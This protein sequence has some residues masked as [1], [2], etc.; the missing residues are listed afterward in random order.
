MEFV[1]AFTGESRRPRACLEAFVLM[2][3]PLAQIPVPGGLDGRRSGGGRAENERS[4]NRAFIP[5]TLGRRVVTA[6]A[7]RADDRGVLRP[8]QSGLSRVRSVLGFDLMH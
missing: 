3:A 6:R 4:V 8:V 5:S 1:N 2:L 7:R